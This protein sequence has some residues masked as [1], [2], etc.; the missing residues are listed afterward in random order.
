[1]SEPPPWDT[2]GQ[3]D[4]GQYPAQ[5]PY[6]HIRK[7]IGGTAGRLGLLQ[8]GRGVI[9]AVADP[10]PEIPTP[11]EPGILC[12]GGRGLHV[13][14]GLADTWGCTPPRHGGKVVWA[15][16]SLKH[17]TAHRRAPDGPVRLLGS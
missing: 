11:K 10:S 9:C 17:L 14:D 16:F 13:I 6:Q 8:P 4:S 15:L 7:G 5:A 1:M 2:S 12:E 3:Q